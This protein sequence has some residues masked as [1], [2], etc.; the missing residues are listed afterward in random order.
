MDRAA[1]LIRYLTINFIFHENHHY[2]RYPRFAPINE[3]SSR[4]HPGPRR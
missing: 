4:R 3:N 1:E 2:Q